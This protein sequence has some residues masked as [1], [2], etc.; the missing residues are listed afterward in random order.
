MGGF[1]DITSMGRIF[2]AIVAREN[3]SHGISASFAPKHKCRH[4]R[5]GAEWRN[6]NGFAYLLSAGVRRLNG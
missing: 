2:R 6:W 3:K 5:T 4:C 1:Q